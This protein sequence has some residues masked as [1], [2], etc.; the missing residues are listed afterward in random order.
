M[1]KAISMSVILITLFITSCSKDN[2]FSKNILA[3]TEWHGV[4]MFQGKPQTN[5]GIRFYEDKAVRTTSN[6]DSWIANSN[7]TTY[8]YK[9]SYPTTELRDL[10]VLKFTLTSDSTAYMGDKDNPVTLKR[11]H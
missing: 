4:I 1:K 3:N 10:Y 9:Y 2:K 6:A 11:I 8:D 5:V 7:S